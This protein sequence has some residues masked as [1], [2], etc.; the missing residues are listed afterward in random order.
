MNKFTVNE[1]Y[2]VVHNEIYIQGVN[3]KWTA[4]KIIGA[5]IKSDICL[6]MTDW[7]LTE[8]T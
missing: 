3:E 8:K 7:P 4:H 1:G 6:N 2:G 5:I